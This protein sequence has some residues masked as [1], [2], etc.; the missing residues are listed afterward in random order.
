MLSP[1][2][3]LGNVPTTRT[4]WFA[5]L[6]LLQGAFQTWTTDASGQ[7]VQPDK[8][9]TECEGAVVSERGLG[10]SMCASPEEGGTKQ[11]IPVPIA[12]FDGKRAY[13]EAVI[14]A[15]HYEP[16]VT[17]AA[18][19]SERALAQRATHRHSDFFS[20]ALNYHLEGA[21]THA[22]D[23]YSAYADASAKDEFWR[24]K[25]LQ[26][27]AW[28]YLLTGSPDLALSTVN[29]FEE[30][31]ETLRTRTRLKLR[32]AQYLAETPARALQVV[33]QID[34]ANL[35]EDLILNK[36]LRLAE[37]YQHLGSPTAAEEVLDQVFKSEEPLL[38]SS[39]TGSDGSPEDL[40]VAVDAV[41]EAKF[42]SAVRLSRRADGIRFPP[43]PRERTRAALTQYIQTKIL[44]YFTRKRSAIELASAAFQE[45]AD[46]KPFPSARWTIAASAEVGRLWADFLEDFN[47]VPLPEG[48]YSRQAY[49]GALDE[50]D[51]PFKEAARAAFVT[52]LNLGVRYKIANRHTRT[53]EEWL[54]G[55]NK[56]DFHLVDEFLP[57][58]RHRTF[59]WQG[60]PMSPKN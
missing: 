58:S 19:E 20:L 25:A 33:Q 44:H 57:Q 13:S 10:E 53:C 60:R 12:Y 45:V 2:L 46:A 22:A 24:D 34:E 49:Y 28:L 38:L 36:R 35:P 39:I 29:K 54:A 26:R 43:L 50:A 42:L 30:R 48:V 5:T 56:G 9:Y 31:R 4:V 47:S 8:A 40:R 6:I 1:N 14:P 17:I 3:M 52:C 7:S 11:T 55:N 16:L 27:A 37:I 59:D 41:G 18:K 15:G 21:F 32:I 51:A 23:A